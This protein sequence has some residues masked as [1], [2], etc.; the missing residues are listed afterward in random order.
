MLNM[1][2]HDDYFDDWK[3]DIAEIAEC[4]NVVAKLGG[5]IMPDN[6]FGFDTAPTPPTS[7]EFLA[8]QRRWYEHTIEC[9]G[10][11]R[12]MFE[13]NFPVD[14]LAIS[15]GVLWN[16]FKRLA[17][18]YSEAEQDAMFRGTAARIYSLDV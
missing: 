16:A 18:Q 10:P 14:R 2:G 9:F 13:S 7:E 1:M 3:R 6:G 11:E 17:S 4:P 15:Y 5:L 12:C 8:V